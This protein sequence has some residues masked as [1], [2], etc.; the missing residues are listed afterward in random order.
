MCGDCINGERRRHRL[1]RLLAPL[2]R[3]LGVFGKAHIRISA[4]MLSMYLTFLVRIPFI[5]RYELVVVDRGAAQGVLVDVLIVILT[6]VLYVLTLYTVLVQEENDLI[7]RK[8]QVLRLI[9][10]C[11]AKGGSA[12]GRGGA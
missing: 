4:T 9:E 11:G 6:L 8:E 5:D 7:S 1:M 3:L 2:S 10:S 12:R